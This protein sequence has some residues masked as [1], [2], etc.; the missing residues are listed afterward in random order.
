MCN[1]PRSSRPFWFD[2]HNIW[3]RL[4]IIKLHI[5]GMLPATVPCYF[6][7]LRSKYSSQHPVLKDPQSP[8]KLQIQVLYFYVILEF[9]FLCGSRSSSDSMV[10]DY[11]LDD[12]AIEVRSPTGA[13]DFSSR[14]Y[15]QT[16][17]GAHPA[18][19]PM[20]TGGPFPG[21]KARPGRDT[22][23]SP[24]SSGRVC[25]GAIYLLFPMRLQGV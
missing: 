5:T 10:S 15:V 21:G 7:H 22:D 23:H 8:F 9:V 11:G 14:L 1:M 24:P 17:S 19:Y 20:S 13:E 3:R 16:G 6:I 4:Q 2:H 12:R 25:V 18:S